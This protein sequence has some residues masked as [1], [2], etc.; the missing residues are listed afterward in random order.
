MK[1]L[2]YLLGLLNHRFVSSKEYNN[3][4]DILLEANNKGVVE[5]R[6]LVS[7]LKDADQIITQLQTQISLKENECFFPGRK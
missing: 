5:R 4:I 7:A 3:R 2:E 6:E 1:F